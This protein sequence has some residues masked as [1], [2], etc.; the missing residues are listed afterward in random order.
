MVFITADS[1]I[2]FKIAMYSEIFEQLGLAKNEARVYETLLREGESPVGHIATK[3]GVHR[4]NVYDT[5]NRLLEKGLVFEILQRNEN[6]YQAVDPNKLMEIV[7][8]KE[9]VLAKVMPDLQK[10]F[11]GTQSEEAVFVYRGPEGWKNYMRDILRLGENA[12]F[13]A[14]KGGWLDERIKNFFPYFEKEAQKKNIRFY[15]LFDHE[16]RDQLPE[17]VPKVGKDFK[18]LPE[19]YSTPAAIDVFGDHVNI[20]SGMKLGGLEE[21]FSLNIIVNQQVADAFRTWFKFMWDFCPE[22]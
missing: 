20:V 18:F 15:H 14:A 11:K 8:E 10:A 19:G 2:I 12:Y 17:I 4:R 16:V 9:S 22:S 5:L 3:S 13:I 7:K 6:I 1:G 21:E